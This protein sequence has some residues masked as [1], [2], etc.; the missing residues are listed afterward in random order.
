M[1]AKLAI[2]IL[3]LNGLMLLSCSSD[4]D[5][6][7]NH[8]QCLVIYG[9]FNLKDSI[10]YIR[11]EKSFQ[12]ED[13][14]VYDIAKISDSVYPNPENLEVIL[15]IWKG[16]TLVESPIIL[17]PMEN[18]AKYPGIFNIDRNLVYCYNEPLQP[19]CRYVL[20]VVDHKNHLEATGSTLLLGNYNYNKSF[21]EQRSYHIRQYSPE[22]IDFSRNI[23]YLSDYENRVIRFCYYDIKGENRIKRYLDWKPFFQ[24]LVYKKDDDTSKVQLTEPYLRYLAEKI[25]VIEGITREAVGLDYMI[26]LA[27]DQMWYYTLN[28]NNPDVLHY[29]EFYSNIENGMGLFASRYYYTYFAKKFNAETLDTLAKGRFTKH[30]NFLDAAGN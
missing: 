30:L 20:L 4:L 11:I 2:S 6:T 18:M 19:G 15:E 28:C 14:N 9:A 7:S 21:T 1:K 8:T 26:T 17:S 13:N 10:Q 5:I 25:P 22:E 12:A 27:D 24:P 29:L 23:D 3:A 16:N